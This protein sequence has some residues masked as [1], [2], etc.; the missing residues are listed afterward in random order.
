MPPA[1]TKL[2]QVAVPD[3]I[4]EIFDDPSVDDGLKNLM[5]W[6]LYYSEDG[7]P[8]FNDRM[9]GVELGLRLAISYP[10]RAQS[11]L[12]ALDQKQE[13][14]GIE[15]FGAMLEDEIKRMM[16]NPFMGEQ[17]ADD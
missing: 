10:S 17:N 15:S 6:L 11:I 14:M 12:S 7:S 2:V 1:E 8:Q 9:F 3:K 16:D 4:V 13:G 5:A